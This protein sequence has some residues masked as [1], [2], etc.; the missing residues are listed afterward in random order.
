MIT[1]AGAPASVIRKTFIRQRTSSLVGHVADLLKVFLD[2][3]VGLPLVRSSVG[4]GQ[5]DVGWLR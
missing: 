1:G 4:I 5:V 2:D 3:P